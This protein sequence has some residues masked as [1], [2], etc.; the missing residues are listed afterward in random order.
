V[1]KKVSAQTDN[2]ITTTIIYIHI[3]KKNPTVKPKTNK[4]SDAA[5]GQEKQRKN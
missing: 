1:T 3:L 2:Q 4:T 5:H